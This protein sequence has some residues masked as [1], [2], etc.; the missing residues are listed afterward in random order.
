M[1]LIIIDIISS[2]LQSITFAYAIF[3][4]M[5]KNYGIAKIKLFS[6]VPIFVVAMSFCTGT[7]GDNWSSIFVTHI[8][9]LSI[10]SVFYRKNI[11]SALTAFSIIYFIIE[12][13]SI[14]FGNLIFEYVKEIFPIEYLNYE[15]I[16]IIYV[17]EWIVL[18]LCFK[19]M[20]KIK[21]IHKFIIN[22]DF[23][24]MFYIMSFVF[25]FIISFYV[26]TLNEENQ[27][28]KNI[29]YMIFILILISIIFYFRTIYQRSKEIYKLNEKLEIK[30][31]ELSKIKNDYG[32]QI[33]YLYG[34]HLM[35]K[36]D[37]IKLSLKNI[38]NNN[39][40][41]PTAIEVSE[42]QESLLSLSLK[43]AID[44]G[45]HVILEE[46]CDL[47]LIK[48]NEMEF[49]RVISN[50]VNNAIKAMEGQ[51]IIIAKSYE[52]LDNAVIK[53]ENTGPKIEETYL[54]DIFKVGFTTKDN[55]DKSH[56]YGLSIVKDLVE[57]YSGK[58]HVK[59][60]DIATE[61]KIVLPIK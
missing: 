24:I 7:F 16:F 48:M 32:S 28:L 56:G 20:K 15:T 5:D 29:L 49:Y 47:G 2:I 35:E 44:N 41:I 18:P 61:F 14:L 54:K 59:S 30:N 25:D 22:E 10:I 58:I 4:C 46:K 3:Y 60:T 38:I 34:L 12:I 45:I 9:C 57:S 26:M 23:Y 37:D 13:Y 55:T 53:I 8:L 6:I 21:Q 52:Y 31:S 33:S 1:T 39:G 27:L 42:N 43:P 51:G 50:I 17:P 40:S 36:F 19:Y 11:V